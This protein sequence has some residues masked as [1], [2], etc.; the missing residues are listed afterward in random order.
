[1]RWEAV[2]GGGEDGGAGEGYVPGGHWTLERVVRDYFV[3]PEGS[4]RG[5]FSAGESH[6]LW[7]WLQAFP[8]RFPPEQENPGPAKQRAADCQAWVAAMMRHLSAEG[9]PFEKIPG[10]HLLELLKHSLRGEDLAQA[11]AREAALRER[12]G[13]GQ[14]GEIF[15]SILNG[16]M[17]RYINQFERKMIMDVRRYWQARQAMGGTHGDSCPD[18]C[19]CRLIPPPGAA[20]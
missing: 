19:L 13:P 4:P 14:E 5:A 12:L 3:L 20:L 11:L 8:L 18:G 7:E 16:A 17:E 2:C 10:R 15:R 1:M 6:A 9:V